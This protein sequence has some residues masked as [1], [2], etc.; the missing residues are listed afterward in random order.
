MEKHASNGRAFGRSG[1]AALGFAALTLSTA[2]AAHAGERED[3]L[4]LCRGAIA[5]AFQV[6]PDEA[7]AH[8]RDST[9]K[10]RAYAMRFDVQAKD[11]AKPLLLTCTVKRGAL[12][13]AELNPKGPGLVE[14]AEFSGA[15]GSAT[16]SA[17]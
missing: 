10:A 11:G 13:V 17:Q 16:P 9:T 12:V 3:A 2:G 14:R 15:A 6:T 8:F 5:E 7:G 1:V 4:A